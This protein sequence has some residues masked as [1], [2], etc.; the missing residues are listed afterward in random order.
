MVPL[1]FITRG[2][3]CSVFDEA[4]PR[5]KSRRR[6]KNAAGAAHAGEYMRC[7][8][9]LVSVTVSSHALPA[10]KQRRRYAKVWQTTAAHY[11]PP[12]RSRFKF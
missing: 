3:F 1:V 11:L 9:S 8:L 5:R 10:R 7:N 12:L 6:D 2:H 4:I